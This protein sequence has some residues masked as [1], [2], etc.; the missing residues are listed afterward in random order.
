MYFSKAVV[1]V[2]QIVEHGISNNVMSSVSKLIN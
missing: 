2:A 1:S